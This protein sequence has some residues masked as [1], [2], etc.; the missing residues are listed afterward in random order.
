MV[1]R[2]RSMWSLHLSKSSQHRPALASGLPADCQK[3]LKEV[4]DTNRL[5][6][7]ELVQDKESQLREESW[8]GIKRSIAATLAV[9]VCFRPECHHN[10]TETIQLYA[11]C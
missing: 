7:Q 10:S 5:S 8:L 11:C 9:I 6:A 4:G 1:G 2:S 3:A